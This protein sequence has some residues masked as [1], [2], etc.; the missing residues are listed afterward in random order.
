[1]KFAYYTSWRECLSIQKH[2]SGHAIG[3]PW[4]GESF[5]KPAS[6]KRPFWK[7]RAT[8]RVAIIFKIKDDDYPVKIYPATETEP[9]ES[10]HE[11]MELLEKSDTPSTVRVILK[12]NSYAS[13]VACEEPVL[14][15][16]FLFC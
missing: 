4:I 9:V 12:N 10:E 6:K 16:W 7:I 15:M 11:M 8:T 2:G 14:R 13:C 3:V 1:M 5:K